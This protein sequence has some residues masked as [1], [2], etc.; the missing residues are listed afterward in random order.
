MKHF[1]DL[2]N[3]K[4]LSVLDTNARQSNKQIAKK[5]GLS[6]DTVGYRI[7]KLEQQGIIKGYRAVID[8][9]KLGFTSYRVLFRLMN[10]NKIVLTELNTFFKRNTEIWGAGILDGEW[11]FSF[12]Y[13][14]KSN[15]EFY[16][17]LEN[18]KSRWRPIIKEQLIS[19][20]IKYQELERGYLSDHKNKIRDT[21]IFE[22]KR[23]DIDIIDYHLLKALT[24]NARSR[25]IDLAKEMHISTMLVYQRIKKLEKN[26]I[27]LGYKAYIDILLLGRDYYGVK[28][29]LLNYS[30]KEKILSYLHLLPEASAILYTIGGY[31]LEFDLEVL[32]TKDY[33][34]IINELRDKFHTILEIK[35][36]GTI[37]YYLLNHFPTMF[38]E[39]KVSN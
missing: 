25:L 30:E 33:Y 21:R 35:K 18:F 16:D 7:R 23:V 3:K 39:P 27:I 1:L 24:N 12:L 11:D 14:S 8:F 29:N 9:S 36:M 32:N 31:D 6:K 10:V 19:P 5:V 34:K 17:F 22:E 2:K 15:K 20:I 28:V 26:K 38:F 13:Y 4:I 37:D